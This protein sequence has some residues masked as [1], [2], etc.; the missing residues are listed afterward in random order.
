MLKIS[1][2]RK[3]PFD[4]DPSKF[5]IEHTVNNEDGE[6]VGYI[7]SP[8]NAPFRFSTCNDYSL[9]LS[10]LNQLTNFLTHLTTHAPV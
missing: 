1:P 7:H 3:Y 5:T 10:D 2:P 4:R 9:S 6:I 8:D